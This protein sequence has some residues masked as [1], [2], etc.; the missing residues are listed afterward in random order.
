MPKQP[1]PP[2]SCYDDLPGSLDHAWHILQEAVRNRR[3]GFRTLAV[4]TRDH[5]GHPNLRT[6]VLRDC[7]P[8]AHRLIF[9]TDNR[10]P[11][12]AEIKAE[13]RA[14]IMGYD[15]EQKLQLRLT[16]L[17]T[18]ADETT[19]KQCWDKT[20]AM[21]R[22]CYQVTQSPSSTIATPDLAVFAPDANS[23]GYDH[24]QPVLA[25][26]EKID[27][28]YLAAQGHRRARFTLAPS[29]QMEWLVP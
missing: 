4:A 26:I 27:W 29:L 15:P 23:G 24:F 5:D 18:L 13:P 12:V 16:C 11:K 2:L 17:L 21:S 19:R 9:N 10:S 20:Q 22:E 3:S 1:P 28:L 6:V 7:Q 8:D 14:M 25:K